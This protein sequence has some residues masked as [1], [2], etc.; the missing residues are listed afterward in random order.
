MLT[1]CPAMCDTFI[2]VSVTISAEGESTPT[3]GISYT[4]NCLVSGVEPEDQLSYLW[5]KNETTISIANISILSL[6]PLRLSDSGLYTCNVTVNSSM[7]YKATTNIT[8][9]SECTFL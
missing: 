1:K 2:S 5:F 4:L 8:L 3:L 9:Q 6:R 7:S